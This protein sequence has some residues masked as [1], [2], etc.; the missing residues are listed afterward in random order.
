MGQYT[1]QKNESKRGVAA[2]YP[3]GDHDKKSLNLLILEILKEFTDKDHR[4][5]QEEILQKLETHYGM[6]CD[7]RSIKSNILALQKLGYDIPLKYGYCLLNRDLEASELRQVI[8][9]VL[10]S[11]ELSRS[12]TMR[13]V[14]RLIALG[15]RYFKPK[16]G[17]IYGL[18]E[19]PSIDKSQ[20]AENLDVLNEAIEIHSQ[21]EFVYNQY[22]TDFQLHPVGEAIVVNPYQIIA[23]NG[24]YYLLG[25][26]NSGDDASY[27]RVDQMTEVSL[28]RLPAKMRTLVPALS[29]EFRMPKHR[30]EQAFMDIG[31]RMKVRL[32]IRP[33]MMD[34]LIDSFG[35]SFE[36]EE[37]EKGTILVNVVCAEE[38]MFR[39]AMLHGGEAE[40][41]EPESIR[42]RVRDTVSRM[43]EAYKE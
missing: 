2:L 4:L 13:L 17:C 39:W 31:E 42:E 21:V 36:V 10:C 1:N 6:K 24:R 11:T 34:V 40:I 22:E 23:A 27:Y 35:K 26:D 41:V 18:P 12:Q 30:V 43:T 3:Y 25:N 37:E 32:R 33:K 8:D 20:I 16:V 19:E 9:C 14:K 7:R 29:K 15:N 28:L 5:K 38:S